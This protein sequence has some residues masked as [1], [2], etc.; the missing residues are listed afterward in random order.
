M[1]IYLIYFLKDNKMGITRSESL[2]K[3]TSLNKN[4]TIQLFLKKLFSNKKL[5]ISEVEFL[6]KFSL[7]L[8]REYE[9]NKSDQ[10]MIEFAYEIIARVSINTNDYTSLYDFSVN[11]GYYPIAQKLLNMDLKYLETAQHYLNQIQLK[12]Y[13]QE[14]K[15]LTLE[16]FNIFQELDTT[17]SQKNY[18]SCPNII[19]KI[20]IYL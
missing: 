14:N 19:W 17:S 12:N 15:T 3:L 7:I 1:K 9:K 5:D 2:K 16:Q 11:Y 13:Q 18:F 10:I 6:L 20:R 8:I 4:P